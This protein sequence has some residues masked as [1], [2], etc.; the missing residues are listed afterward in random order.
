MTRRQ[1]PRLSSVEGPPRFSGKYVVAVAGFCFWQRWCI[2]RMMSHRIQKQIIVG[3]VTFVAVF[4]IGF[5]A[6][7]FLF[8]REKPTPPPYAY[9]APV[10]DTGP[11]LEN[12]EV[13]F[14]DFFEIRKFNTY[15]AVAYIRNPNIEYGASSLLYEFAFRDQNGQELSRVVGRAFILPEQSRYIIK[16]AIEIPGKPKSMSFLVTEVEWQRLGPFS[17]S[18]LSMRDLKI[19]RDEET[20]VTRF[21]G[22]VQNRTPYNL[23]NVQA[24][25]VFFDAATPGQGQGSPSEIGEDGTLGVKPLPELF[26][27]KSVAAGETNMQDLLRSTDRFFQITWPYTLPRNLDFDARVE[28]NFFENSNFLREFGKPG[29]FKEYYER[30]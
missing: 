30:E 11:K 12:L 18:G 7:F 22:I 10:V 1:G 20:Q 9:P 8:G 27:G 5:G 23:K 29:K 13:L 24:Q 28:S 14:T 6:V 16:A 4:G 19:E 25:V 15:D 2:M 3:F 21:S 17:A 26:Q